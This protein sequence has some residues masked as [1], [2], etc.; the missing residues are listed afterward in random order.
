MLLATADSRMY[1]DKSRLK[2]PAGESAPAEHGTT[3]SAG[4]LPDAV[5]RRAAVG[6]L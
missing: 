1:R 6:V 4:A 3:E 2:R 5:V